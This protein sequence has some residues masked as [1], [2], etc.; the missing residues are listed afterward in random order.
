MSDEEVSADS[1]K[2]DSVHTEAGME[3]ECGGVVF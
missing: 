2:D 3:Q 1:L